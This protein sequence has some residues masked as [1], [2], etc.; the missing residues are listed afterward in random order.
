MR[1]GAHQQHEQIV[2]DAGRRRLLGGE[3]QRAAGCATEAAVQSAV[4]ISRPSAV[5]HITSL[6]PDSP[7]RLPVRNLLRRNTGCLRRSV[8]QLADELR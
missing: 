6:I 4:F 8:E 1:V 7:T 3:Q 2:L 5:S